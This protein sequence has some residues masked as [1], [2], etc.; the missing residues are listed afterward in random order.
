MTLSAS[1]NIKEYLKD[2]N[3][4]GMISDAQLNKGLMAL[5]KLRR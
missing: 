3:N 4:H 5:S 1:N 2:L